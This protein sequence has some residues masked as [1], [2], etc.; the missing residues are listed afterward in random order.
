MGS[1]SSA[2]RK[3]KFLIVL[4]EYARLGK[5]EGIQAITIF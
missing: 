3:G 5:V 4:E 2:E 1:N